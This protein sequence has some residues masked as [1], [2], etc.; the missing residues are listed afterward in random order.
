MKRLIGVIALGISLFSSSLQADDFSTGPV[1]VV[2]PFSAGGATD[3]FSRILAEKLD[4]YLSNPVIVENRPGA[5]GTVAAQHV[6]RSKPDGHTL[7]VTLSGV[8]RQPYLENTNY[9]PI[10]DLDYVSLIADFGLSVVVRTDSD[11]DSMRDMIEYTKN[12]PQEVFY[13]VPALLGTQDLTMMQLGEEHNLEWNTVAYPGDSQSLVSL[14]AGDIDASIVAGTVAKSMV[15]GGKVKTIAT[16]NK[17]RTQWHPD[18]PTWVEEGLGVFANAPIGIAVASGTPPE[19][20]DEL[21]EL[22]KKALADED[23]V[24]RAHS[25]GVIPMYGDSKEYTDYAITFYKENE[26]IM[27]KAK[28]RQTQ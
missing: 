25:M 1:K 19:I 20:I 8:F 2:V 21:D 3:V 26:E 23:L 10:E 24:Q 28:E 15:D 17:D 7:L 18:V 12:N 14:V 4:D 22:I 6:M 11:W 5:N 13:G 16:L 27:K 9:D